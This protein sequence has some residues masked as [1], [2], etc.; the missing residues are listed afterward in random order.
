MLLVNTWDEI[1]AEWQSV[2]LDVP[3]DASP[4][5][6]VRAVDEATFEPLGFAPSEELWSLKAHGRTGPLLTIECR[7][8]RGH[9]GIILL[10]FEENGFQESTGWNHVSAR[11]TNNHEHT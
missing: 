5:E 10:N 2:E 3:R 6:I 11:P 9:L 8:S 1:S 7:T 4:D